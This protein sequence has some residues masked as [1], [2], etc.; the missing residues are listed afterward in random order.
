MY[1]KISRILLLILFLSVIV[2]YCFISVKEV[3]SLFSKETESI[4]FVDISNNLDTQI[5]SSFS[6]HH[7]F[8]DIKGLIYKIL[9]KEVIGDFEYIKDSGGHVRVIS[10]GY[11]SSKYITSLG[12]VKKRLDS[13]NIPLVFV[14]LID[15]S[16]QLTGHIDV[17]GQIHSEILDYVKEQNID[18]IDINEIID[19]TTLQTPAEF[20][21]DFH[22]TTE[23]EL[24]IA[25]KISSHLSDKYEIGIA[26]NV[27]IYDVEN[28]YMVKYPFRGNTVRSIGKYFTQD[29]LFITYKPKFKTSFEKIVPQHNTYKTG[30]FE[31]TLLNGYE[32]RD[33]NDEETYWV[34]DFGNYP[35]QYYKIT[36]NEIDDGA[37]LLIVCDSIF[38]RGFS[39]LSLGYK[40]VTI[41]DPRV[42]ENSALFNLLINNN[43]DAVIFVGL[44]D[45]YYSTDCKVSYSDPK[46][47]N[48]VNRMYIDLCS[49]GM[50]DNE[51]YK[52]TTALTGDVSLQGWA[53]DGETNSPLKELYLEVN[54]VLFK[55][56]Y[57][58]EM[59]SVASYYNNE[60][61]RY[62]G[63]S[64]SFP[65]QIFDSS[66]NKIKFY[67][68]TQND[69]IIQTDYTINDLDAN[70][71]LNLSIRSL[72]NSPNNLWIDYCNN[73]PQ[74]EEQL[75]ITDPSSSDIY[76]ITGWAGDLIQ[77]CAFGGLY[78]QVGDEI[79]KCNYGEERSIVA[80]VYQNENLRYT[81][82]SVSVPAE[83]FT[84]AEEIRFIELSS[85]RS[86]R[87]EDVIYR[88]REDNISTDELMNYPVRSLE[89]S[90]N[91]IWVDYC[92]GI[93]QAEE[94]LFHVAG[95]GADT[96]TLKGWSADLI[97][98]VP[99]SSL[100]V[101]VG[102]ELFKCC[103]GGERA[104]VAEVYQ[105]EALRYSGFSVR[106]PADRLMG[107]DHIE[108][109]GVG[110]DKSFRYDMSYNIQHDIPQ[111]QTQP[112]ESMSDSNQPEK[113]SKM[114]II[115]T[116]FSA[117]FI[118]AL[119]VC[120]AIFIGMP[121]KR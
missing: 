48:D 25:K 28:Y 52:L 40:S 102:E 104:I 32:K 13:K 94:R 114:D 106:I 2:I 34:T 77:G 103:Y 68:I 44:S 46:K 105:N 69:E 96:I 108:F 80:E 16:A 100:Y 42:D 71:I 35:S 47:E 8:K 11:D 20:R 118:L 5:K 29:D 115:S 112:S 120:T 31:D 60:N 36:N 38:M 9:G 85:D 37:D 113:F 84:G 56:S 45:D 53:I 61:L 58:Y 74:L 93:V 81:G 10:D 90:P 116:A 78:L 91:N 92:N 117:A 23:C 119:G 55:C 33:N 73:V 67:K 63:F 15:A 18:Y 41:Y 62:T 19:S 64:V 86:Y 66:N 43:Y 65:A 30:N 6:S 88:V 75:L 17:E 111:Q 7:Y 12:N 50:V 1:N 83:S 4:D 89:S 22:Y 57:G 97:N 39:Y 79:F 51:N 99:F 107:T 109:I 14:N 95:D 3:R 59:G 87:Y 27:D 26:G 98:G 101:K 82:F 72:E 49:D 110:S 21:T 76:T 70:E 54:Q 121:K 24:F